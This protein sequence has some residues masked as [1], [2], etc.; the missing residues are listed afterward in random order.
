MSGSAELALVLRLHCLKDFWTREMTAASEKTKSA[1]E[2]P[3][4]QHGNQ[5]RVRLYAIYPMEKK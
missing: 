3:A 2:R 1:R 5:D 4:E